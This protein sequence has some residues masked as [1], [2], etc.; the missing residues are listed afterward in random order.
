MLGDKGLCPLKIS[1][2]FAYAHLIGDGSASNNFLTPEIR[3]LTKKISCT[4]ADIVGIC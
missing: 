1:Q 4:L 2:S 3:K